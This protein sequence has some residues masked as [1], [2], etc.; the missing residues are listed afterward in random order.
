MIEPAIKPVPLLLLWRIQSPITSPVSPYEIV[1]GMAKRVP[2]IREIKME[3]TKKTRDDLRLF[4]APYMI[5]GKDKNK[6]TTAPKIGKYSVRS[7][8]TAKIASKIAPSVSLCTFF[9]FPP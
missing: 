1:K 6:F 2:T 8:K 7:S 9:N 4:F 5:N 3:A